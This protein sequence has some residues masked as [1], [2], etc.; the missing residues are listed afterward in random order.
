MYR[1]LARGNL[2]TPSPAVNLASV[3]ERNL[4]EVLVRSALETR[5]ADENA[6][7]PHVLGSDQHWK[8]KRPLMLAIGALGVVY[9]DIGTSPLYTIKECFHGKHAITLT[10]DNVYGVMSLVFWSLTVVVSIKYVLF[11]LRADN[12]GEGGIFALLGLIS[13]ERTKMS[14]RLRSVA[15]GAGILGAGL[16][17]GDGI[18]TPA[19]SVLSAIEGLAVATQAAQP[20]VLPLTC[21]VLLFLFLLQRRGTGDIG[22]VFGPVMA[23]WFGTI[24]AL[25]VAHIA[26]EPHILLAV[27]PVYAYNFFA[28]NHLHA[29]VVFGSVVLCLT[30]G[31][32]LYADLG[33]FGRKAIRLSWNCLV[34]PALLCNYFGQGALLI[35][36]PEM[37]SNPFYGLVPTFLLYPM[38]ALATVATAIASQALIS[39]VFS[40]TQQAIELGLCPRLL[41]VHTSDEVRGQ[42]YMPAVNYGLMVACLGVVIGFGGS[43]GLAGAYGIAVTGTMTITSILYFLLLTHAWGWPLWKAVPLVAI[44]LIFDISYFGA[45]LLKV[46]DG[47]WFTLLVAALIT[48]TLTTWRKGRAAVIQKLGSRMPLDLF[49]EDLARHNL[50][51]VKGTAVFMSLFPKGTSPVL[52]HHLKHNKLLHEKVVLLSVLSADVPFVPEGERVKCE[53]LGQGFY[54]VVAYN[55]FMQVPNVPRILKLA[56]GAGLEMNMADTS[57]Y[58]GRV[59][60][61]PTG[62]SKMMRWRKRLFAFM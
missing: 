60:A 47:G 3:D 20:A 52:L 31:E 62:D 2:F 51:R 12:H 49:L 42:I 17:Y 59:R 26:Q 24:A 34:F 54:R 36:H 33:H 44:F 35:A 13:R 32:A 57:Y 19:I 38:V 6:M 11:I 25:G 4:P 9:G 29:F 1:C 56:S 18:I 39:G 22:K 55:G 30:G 61:V 40:L 5:P 43:S 28:A 50:P 10:P 37:S 27:Y 14:S 48:L 15:V 53:Y 23:L 16:L 41:I 21:I 46:V 8:T 7:S 58:L 45:N